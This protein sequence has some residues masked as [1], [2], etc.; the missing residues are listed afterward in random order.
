MIKSTPAAE[1]SFQAIAARVSAVSIA[2][3]LLLTAAKL[4]AGIFAHSEAMISDAV[5]SVSDV[6]STVVVL[7]GIRL[8]GKESDK[9]HPYGHERLECVAAI[10]LSA[11]LLA[12]GL[13]I[14]YFACGKI[15]SEDTAELAVPG[16]LALAA[17][18]LSILSKEAMFWYTKINAKRIDSGALMADAWHHRSDSLSSVGALIG[19]AGARLGFPA[20]DPI[21]SL[22]ICFFIA[23]AAYDIFM[24]AVKKMVDQ[25]CDDHTEAALLD[26]ALAQD[27]VLGVDVLHTRMFGNKVYVDIEIRAD[28]EKKLRDAHEIAEKVHN[29]IEQKFPKVKHIMVHV[30]P[31]N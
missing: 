6:F 24:D 22:V 29:S 21:A 17:A 8:A 14:G 7:I 5:H 15:R 16:R 2:G 1:E 25:S 18:V 3:N 13:A 31:G 20:A 19:I 10:L 23:K 30:N 11:L 28:G 26:C 27:G 12:T 4:L 9:E